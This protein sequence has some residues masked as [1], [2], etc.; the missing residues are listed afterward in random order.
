MKAKDLLD[1]VAELRLLVD[2]LCAA[3]LEPQKDEAHERV[4]Q[5]RAV[6]AKYRGLQHVRNC[7]AIDEYQDLKYRQQILLEDYPNIQEMV[8]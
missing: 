4:R 7:I 2:S 8:K 5:H 1:E 6:K 3:V